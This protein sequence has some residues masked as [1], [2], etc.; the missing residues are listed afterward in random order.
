MRRGG[1]HIADLGPPTGAEP[2]RNRPIQGSCL[3]WQPPTG[4][5]HGAGIVTLEGEEPARASRNGSLHLRLP[6][7][8]RALAACA[9]DAKTDH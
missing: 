6:R 8:G 7:T 1:I 5:S 9:N 2:A 4:L 3:G